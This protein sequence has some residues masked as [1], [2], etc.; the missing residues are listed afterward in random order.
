MNSE[1]IE[2]LT[3]VKTL[4]SSAEHWCRFSNAKDYLSRT[5]YP[6]DKHAVAFCLGGAIYKITEGGEA[7]NRIIHYLEK[8][9]LENVSVH[10]FNDY[11]CVSADA[12]NEFLDKVI[13]ECKIDLSNSSNMQNS[14]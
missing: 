3:K 14:C 5:C 4:F 13:T 6:L 8:F 7:G 2:V 11:F 12:L 9:F 1:I 10:Q